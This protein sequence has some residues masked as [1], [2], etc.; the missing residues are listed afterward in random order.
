M[1]F[2]TEHFFLNIYKTIKNSILI[3]FKHI[4]DK[5]FKIDYL[6]DPETL[7]RLAEAGDPSA[8]FLVG[9]AYA[10][11][12]LGFPLNINEGIRWLE[13]SK[14]D[15]PHVAGRCSTGFCFEGDGSI[16][17]ALLNYSYANSQHYVP[18]QYLYI[19]A[20]YEKLKLD[21]LKNKIVDK[22]LKTGLILKMQEISNKGFTPATAFL[23]LRYFDGWGVD[24]DTNQALNLL[25]YAAKKGDGLARLILAET[26]YYGIPNRVTMNKEKAIKW[27]RLAAEQDFPEAIQSLE[28]IGNKIGQVLYWI[29]K[30]TVALLETMVRFSNRIYEE[31]IPCKLERLSN[32]NI[33]IYREDHI[34]ALTL[35]G[36]EKK[37]EQV[38]YNEN[39]ISE[40]VLLISF[41]ICGSP[42]R[43][44]VY[45]VDN[46]RRFLEATV[47]INARFKEENEPYKIEFTQETIDEFN[48]NP[49]ILNAYPLLKEAVSQKN[50]SFTTEDKFDK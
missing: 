43:I 8:K 20:M 26:Y 11:G 5:I 41:L 34:P 12:R 47:K 22:S 45:T 29:P 48:K 6:L 19:K 35:S 46:A 37:V 2:D 9:F 21:E 27:Y 50:R 42:L 17:T 49:E 13:L 44:N 32:G 31:E 15:W 28:E 14:K 1:R 10:Y 7:K 24:P 23:G 18:G 3:F 36:F 39:F 4:K 33:V 30:T 40:H 16:R 38:T 25:N